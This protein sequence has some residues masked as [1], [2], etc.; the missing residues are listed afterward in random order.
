MAQLLEE[1]GYFRIP[2]QDD[3]PPYFVMM[4][5][6]RSTVGLPQEFDEE[7]FASSQQ[8][9]LLLGGS[10]TWRGIHLNLYTS[11]LESLKAAAS[12]RKAQ[13]KRVFERLTDNT[14]TGSKAI[15]VFAGDANARDAEITQIGGLPTRTVDVWTAAGAS[16]DQQFTWDLA[17]NPNART[18]FVA[19]CRFDRA[20][21][22]SSADQRV[23]V[24]DF[25]LIGLRPTVGP[26]HPSDHFGLRFVV[27]TRSL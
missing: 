9:R 16:K 19:R 11:H 14:K 2:R 1:R 15:A 7:H 20:Y 22:A 6:K 13:L 27:D 21:L 4:F 25:E 3:W 18:T 12:Q 23:T 10:F 17:R 26:L 8:G 24:R 5:T